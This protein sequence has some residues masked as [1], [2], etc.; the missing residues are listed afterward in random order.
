MNRK[1]IFSS[2]LGLYMFVLVVSFILSVLNVVRWIRHDDYS[3]WPFW[4]LGVAVFIHLF[5]FAYHI[6]TNM[7]KNK[8]L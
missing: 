3:K 8:K 5:F 1:L 6:A 7:D 2:I 4:V